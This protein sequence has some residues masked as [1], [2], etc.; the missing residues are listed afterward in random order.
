MGVD[1]ALLP[2]M[3]ETMLSFIVRR[4]STAFSD[5][6]LSCDKPGR[7]DIPGTRQ[8]YDSY[9]AS[10][11]MAG[12]LAAFAATDAEHVFLT[13][14]D[15]PFSSPE[16]AAW[17]YDEIGSAPVRLFRYRNFLEPLYGMYSRRLVSKI[18]QCLQ[19][20]QNS[21][22]HIIDPLEADILEACE[23]DHSFSEIF[24][25]INTFDDYQRALP[26]FQHYEDKEL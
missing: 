8:V 7:Y 4:Y 2:V 15:M 13:A 19:H 18:E 10:G 3:R 12:L 9:P 23:Q 24:T 6:I 11:P 21:L 26:R 20:N 5:I 1:K 16:L 17:L 14:V 25:N 22:R